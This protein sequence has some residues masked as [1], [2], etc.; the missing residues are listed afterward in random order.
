MPPSPGPQ[1]LFIVR[2]IPHPPDVGGRIRQRNLLT[3]Y[4]S[5]GRV[6]LVFS[7]ENDTEL[8]GMNALGPLCAGIYPVPFDWCDR[9]KGPGPAQWRKDLREF[10]TLRPFRSSL[11]F[12]RE[13]QQT[14]AAVAPSCDLIHVDSPDL[15]P[16]V[17]S[18]LMQRTRSQRLVLDLDDIET[19]VRRAWLRVA[20][21][22]GCAARVAEVLDVA[23]LWRE[24]R[25]ALRRFDRVL[26]CSERDRAHLGGGPRITVIPNG[27]DVQRDP[28]P[29][30]SDGRTLLC[31]GTYGHWP[32]VDGLLFF[33]REVLPRIQAEIAEVRVLVVGKDMPPEISQL[34][35]GVRVLVSADVPSIEPFY[36]EATASVV[37]LRI[38]GGTRLKILEAFALGRPVVSTSVGCEGLEVVA[39]E[40][41]LVADDPAALA[42]S[43]IELLRNPALRTRL[44]RQARA[45]VV[46]RYSW[47]SIRQRAAA[48]AN[49]LLGDAGASAPAHDA[50]MLPPEGA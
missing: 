13:M 50:A 45:L 31:L 16:H 49:E 23:L 48:M 1:I 22:V 30:C 24:Q 42:R 47:E 26:A 10:R 44:A 4:A 6:R 12:S 36:R 29:D 11:F 14:V 46:Q 7:Y 20:P 27:A 32:N 25:R 2:Q 35:D 37:P 33:F 40:H 28:L 39:G 15:V 8:A 38:G 41:L 21:P 5:V 19:R 34:H 43:C 18:V 3:A 17:E 9:P